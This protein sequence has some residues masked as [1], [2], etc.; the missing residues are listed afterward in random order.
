MENGFNNFLQGLKCKVCGRPLKTN[1]KHIKY[2][3]KGWVPSYHKKCVK[4]AGFLGYD[5]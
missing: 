3:E 4:I 5:D 1:K 2:Y